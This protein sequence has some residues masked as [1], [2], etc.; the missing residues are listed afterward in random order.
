[1][2]VLPAFPYMNSIPGIFK[3]KF[4][5]AFTAFMAWMLFFDD[6]NIVEQINRLKKL[7][8]LRES[9]KYYDEKINTA[10]NEL[11][12]RAADPAAYER[13]AREIGRAHV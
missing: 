1:M 9:C 4:F 10:S 7:N 5:L 8:Q 6:N 12:K 2:P 13:I 3:N 11:K